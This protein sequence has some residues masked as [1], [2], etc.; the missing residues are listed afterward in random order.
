MSRSAMYA[1][2]MHM[3]ER[4]YNTAHTS[5]PRYGGRGIRVCKQWHLFSNYFNHFGDIPK[6]MSI[7]RIDVDGNYCPENTRLVTAKVQA[8]NK[9]NNHR[10]TYRNETRT[11]MEWSELL[12]INYG[13][14]KGRIKRGWTVEEAFETPINPTYERYDPIVMDDKVFSVS[15]LAKTTGISRAGIRGRIRSGMSPDQLLATCNLQHHPITWNNQTRNISDWARSVGMSPDNLMRRLDLGWDF[16]RAIT[17]PIKTPQF[18]DVLD[19]K[20]L[21]HVAA[22]V[23]INPNTLT[24]RLKAGMDLDTAI[25]TPVK[26]QRGPI[27]FNGRTMTLK[28]WADEFGIQ[29]RTLGNRLARGWSVEKALTTPL[30]VNSEKGKLFS[31]GGKTQSLKQWSEDLGVKLATLYKRLNKGWD[32]ERV[33]SYRKGK[34]PTA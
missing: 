24:N 1:R 28:A 11:M 5:F 27:S 3:I 2:W 30:I 22:D 33:L 34:T 10:L 15:E 6:G 17:T 25:A 21:Q 16:E 26:E 32:I 31:F 13:T 19:N 4:C 29:D 8:N 18:A 23:G 14:L 7:D 12:G 20:P 9:R